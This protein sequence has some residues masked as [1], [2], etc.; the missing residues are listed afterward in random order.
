MRRIFFA[1][2]LLG[3]GCLTGSANVVR[4][5]RVTR[6]LTR[7]ER[8]ARQAIDARPAP[9]QL[10]SIRGSDYGSVGA[11]RKELR[12]LVQAIDRAT[13]IRE[14]TAELLRDGRDPDLVQRFDRA[15]A[16]RNDAIHAADDLANAL[17]EARGGLTIADLRPAF[18]AVHKAQAS[19]DRLAHAAPPAGVRLAPSAL[20]APRP[21]HQAAA[22][23]VRA[24]PE[25]ARD[26]DR[27]A[28]D[29]QARIRALMGAAG[30]GTPPPASPQR[31]PLEPSTPGAQPPSA[32]PPSA[33]APSAQ[34]PPIPE[35]EGD[36]AREEEAPAPS[37]T[38]KIANDAANLMSKKP[39]REITLREDGLFAL[40]Y[41]DGDY[42]VD[43]DGKLVRKEKPQQK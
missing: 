7:Q 27:L 15:G 23:L 19:E 25:L 11:A 13:W 10:E 12:K 42:L 17:A 31:P 41:D 36:T 30:V 1:L 2:L 14:T 33:Q 28:P 18:E 4:D 24:H 21:F 37:S 8:W 20:P 40:T 32:Q 43:P 9:D 29:D 5:D 22:T 6:E 39:P 34:P 16:L 38:L 3:T 26:L 35:G